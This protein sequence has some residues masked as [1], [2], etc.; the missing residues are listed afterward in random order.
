MITLCCFTGAAVAVLLVA[1][2]FAEARDAIQLRRR[3]RRA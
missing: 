2:V 1:F 3:T